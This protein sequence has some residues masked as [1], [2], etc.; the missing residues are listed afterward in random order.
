MLRWFGSGCRTKDDYLE[1]RALVDETARTRRRRHDCWLPVKVR[2][3]IQSRI[4]RSK[5]VLI[6]EA[7]HFSPEDEPGPVT[8]T[9]T[10]LLR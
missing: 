6:P 3:T 8:E 1:I 4:P 10:E 2:A 9:I 5:L 7:G